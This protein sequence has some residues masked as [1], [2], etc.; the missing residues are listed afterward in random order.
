[1]RA[2]VALGRRLA[3]GRRRPEQLL[4]PTVGRNCSP[5]AP[6]DPAKA[7]EDEGT[8]TSEEACDEDAREPVTGSSRAAGFWLTRQHPGEGDLRARQVPLARADDDQ[9]AARLLVA[10]AVDGCD[11]SPRPAC[12]SVDLRS[13]R[14]FG[15]ARSCRWP[16]SGWLVAWAIARR[17]SMRSKQSK[18]TPCQTNR[19]LLSRR[20]PWQLSA[21]RAHAGS[22]T[23]S[24]GIS[25]RRATGSIR[26]TPRPTRSRASVVSAGSTICPRPWAAWSPWCR[27]RR[28]RTW[29]RTAPG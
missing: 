22:A 9:S 28:P 24:S 13:E 23:A 4:T 20:R 5:C 17:C 14:G 27:P 3:S 1:M 16:R 6:S 15:L 29:S 10:S 19:K 21:C 7:S 18:G 25:S 2:H 8:M 12:L 11:T 26:S